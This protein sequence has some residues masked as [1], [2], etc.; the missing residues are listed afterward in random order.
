ML[1]ASAMGLQCLQV[2]GSSIALMTSKSVLRILQIQ[3]GTPMVTGDLGQNGG[4]R[5]GRGISLSPLTTA[6]ALT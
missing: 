2:L 4:S 6:S 3:F 5:N 1:R